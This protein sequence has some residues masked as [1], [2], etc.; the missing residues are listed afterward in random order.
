MSKCWNH[1]RSIEND[2]AELES[3]NVMSKIK[4]DSYATLNVQFENS[5]IY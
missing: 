4:M 3:L 5:A 1:V 2:N